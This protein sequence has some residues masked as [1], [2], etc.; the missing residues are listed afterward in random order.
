[1]AWL[2]QVRALVGRGCVNAGIRLMD[3]GGEMVR[4]AVGL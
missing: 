4:V 1:M 3:A 2:G